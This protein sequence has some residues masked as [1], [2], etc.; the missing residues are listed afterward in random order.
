M[1][2]LVTINQ[3]FSGWREL[4]LSC[5]GLII[6]VKL[7]SFSGSDYQTYYQNVLVE[8]CTLPGRG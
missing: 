8:N 4:N 1:M 5:S 2:V 6:K 3:E 7:F